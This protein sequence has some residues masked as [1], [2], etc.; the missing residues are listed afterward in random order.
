MSVQLEN[1]FLGVAEKFIP[2]PSFFTDQII[3]LL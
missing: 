3:N 2:N 1:I